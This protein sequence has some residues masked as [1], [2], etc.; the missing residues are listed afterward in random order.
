MNILKF[1]TES[2]R[3]PVF[4]GIV[5]LILPYIYSILAKKD[6]YS[7]FISIPTIFWV[8]LIII[9]VFWIISIAIRKK[10]SYGS[11]PIGFK[12][13]YGW[14][15]IG[16]LLYHDVIWKVRTINPGPFSNPFDTSKPSI[17]L[18]NPPRCPNC[19]TQLEIVDNY[20]WYVW[21]CVRCDFKKRTWDTFKKTEERAKLIAKRDI[22]MIEEEPQ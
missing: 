7:V 9:L 19:E 5:V 14:I 21:N 3:S 6:W 20:Y 16:K 8:V 17:Y 15:D 12:P 18:E 2:Y 10:M 4:A 1:I 11:V 13:T 22:E